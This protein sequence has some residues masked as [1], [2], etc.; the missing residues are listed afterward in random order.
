MTDGYPSD[1]I[2]DARPNLPALIDA[3][4]LDDPLV[5]DPPEASL[6]KSDD[7]A[8][9][10]EPAEP[11]LPARHEP[12]TII[13][14]RMLDRASARLDRHGRVTRATLVLVV[15]PSA[16]WARPLGQLVADGTILSDIDGAHLHVVDR[17]VRQIDAW[18]HDRVISDLERGLSAVIATAD[19]ALL[20]ADVIASVDLRIEVEPPI[21]DDLLDAIVQVSGRRPCQWPSA[22]AVPS[23]TTIR[24]AFRDRDDPDR[25]VDRLVRASASLAVPLGADDAPPL[26]K[27]HGYGATMP[28]AKQL[29]ADVKRLRAGD[30]AFADIAKPGCVLAGPPGTGKTTF[31]RSLAAAAGLPLIATSCAR[32]FTVSSGHLGA[33]VRAVTDDFERA[34]AAAP[35]ILFI[36][37]LDALPSREALS[38]DEA[39]WWTPLVTAVL[40][41]TDGAVSSARKG[42]IIVGATNH[43]N[44]LDPAL[45]RPGRF[46]QVFEVALPDRDAVAGILGVHAPD[47][48]AVDA[49]ALGPILAGHSGAIIA[50]L[51]RDARARGPL[52]FVSILK[53]LSPED[54]DVKTLRACAW[55]E[56]GHAIVAM[57]LGVS[58]ERVSTLQMGASGGHVGVPAPGPYATRAMI[59]DFVTVV[60]GGRAA[61]L[62]AQGATTGALQDLAIATNVIANAHDRFGLG[63]H[64]IV[65]DPLGSDI[66]SRVSFDATLRATVER[67]LRRLLDRASAILKA[68]VDGHRRLAK[69]LVARRV[70][71]GPAAKRAAGRL[72][73]P[74][75]RRNDP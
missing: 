14:T 65:S 53:A 35:A 46:E 9:S 48:P 39:S 36:D 47:L 20:T 2:A 60:L 55:H 5:S 7:D 58:I 72:V 6:S 64:L 57:A 73:E 26:D 4:A 10:W 15:A 11:A 25:I 44:R 1:A 37:E 74:L 29:V 13:A 28:W 45:L 24:L 32:W 49:R 63:D 56:A 61:D 52:T 51:V 17:P 71:D 68:N 59:E 41:L 19:V 3:L 38:A 62:M 34:R 43:R 21:V 42:V 23:P 40:T 8:S 27:L 31:V 30:I 69:A 75:N 16:H 18:N 54:H 70:L 12:V 66:M 50:G 67:D 22:L 33:V